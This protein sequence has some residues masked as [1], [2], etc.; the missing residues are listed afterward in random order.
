MKRWFRLTMCEIELV[1]RVLLAAYAE[2]FPQLQILPRE[3]RP[4]IAA[5]YR[6]FPPH[7]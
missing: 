3:D 2:Q 6:L 7:K 4:V 1:V 5:Q